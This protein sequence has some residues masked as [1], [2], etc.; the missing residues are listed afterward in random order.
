M[1]LKKVSASQFEVLDKNEKSIFEF[2]SYDYERLKNSQVGT[3]IVK[4]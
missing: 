1:K 3:S 2:S 4:Y